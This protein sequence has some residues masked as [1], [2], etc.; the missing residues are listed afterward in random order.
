MNQQSKLKMKNMRNKK[1]I[2][3]ILVL[4]L[5][6]PVFRGAAQTFP[7]G[8][9]I[10]AWFSDTAVVALNTLGKKYRVTDHGVKNDSTVV[11]TGNIQAVIDKAAGEGGGVIII[12]KGVFL[13]GSLFFKPKTHLYL[14][15]GATLKCSDHIADFKIVTTRIEGQSLKCF[16]ALVNAD[17]LD[18]F[19]VSGRGTINGNGLNYW[20][21]FWLRRQ[22]NPKCTNMDEQRP[23]LLFVSNSKHVQ[24][25]GVRLINSPFWTSHYYKCENL[26]VLGVCILAGTNNGSDV[27]APSS[28]GIDLDVCQNVLIKNCYISVNDDGVCLKGGKGPLADKDPSNGPNRNIIIEDNTF[29]NCPSLTL[30]SESVF[31]RNVIMRRCT[32]KNT[33]HVLLLKMRPDTPQQHE[34]VLVEDITGTARNFLSIAP[35]TQFFDL[36]G[37]PEPRSFARYITMRNSRVSCAAFLSIRSSGQYTLSDLVL[38]NLR[39]TTPGETAIALDFIKNLQ[40]KNIVV[41][42]KQLVK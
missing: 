33:S 22:W 42:D 32:V 18:G 35:W 23:R 40:L 25:S 6:A 39:M 21:A 16:A 10:P 15:E 13:S 41:N 2:L 26:K 1:R 24:I 11:Q 36:K 9:P 7:D 14:E 20:K 12:P 27:R 3:F 34:Y 17:G 8:T 4:V 28:D 30:G 37:Q 29:D 31:T 5:T 38:E 19:T